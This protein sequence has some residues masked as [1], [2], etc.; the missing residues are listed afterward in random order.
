[1]KICTVLIQAS[2][3]AQIKAFLEKES[4][5]A[6]GIIDVW[7]YE[8]AIRNLLTICEHFPHDMQDEELTSETYDVSPEA[9][10]NDTENEVDP[11][12]RPRP[13]RYTWF[14]AINEA[15]QEDHSACEELLQNLIFRMVMMSKLQSCF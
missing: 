5:T 7:R 2:L 12:P 6:Y 4:A 3:A 8:S 14:C 1:M 11:A 13:L 10:D 9:G 15:K